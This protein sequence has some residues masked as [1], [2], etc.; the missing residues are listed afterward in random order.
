M[1]ASERED[2]DE[3]AYPRDEFYD[4]L[5]RYDVICEDGLTFAVPKVYRIK[6]M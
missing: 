6:P 4:C 3:L 1:P 2:T 5:T